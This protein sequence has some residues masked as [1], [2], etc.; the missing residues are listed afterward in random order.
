MTDRFATSLPGDI[1]AGTFCTM[2]SSPLAA[3]SSMVGILAYSRGVL[4]PS[5]ATGSSDIPSP[6]TTMYF[7]RSLLFSRIYVRIA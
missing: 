4:P 2:P 1:P 6:K 7:I 3:R 5:S